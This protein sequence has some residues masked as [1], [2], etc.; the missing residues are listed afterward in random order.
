MSTL[1]VLPAAKLPSHAP[2]QR[3]LV[4]HLWG[5]EAVGIIGGE[6]KCC[7]SFLALDLAVSVASGSACLGRFPVA[8][9]ARVLLFAAEDPLHVVRERLEGITAARG[10]SLHNL[11][12]FVITATRLRLDDSGCCE[13]LGETV[14]KAAPALLVLDP[15]VRLHAVDEN[16]AGEVAPLLGFLRKLQRQHHLAVA[17]VHHARKDA[18]RSRPGQAL[19]GSSEFHAWGDSNLYLRRRDQLLRL[20]VEHRAAAAPDDLTLELATDPLALRIADAPPSEATPQHQV[21]P[22]ARIEQALLAARAPLGVR[23]LRALCHIRTDTL[24]TTLDALLAAGRVI[25]TTDGYT[26]AV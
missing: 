17:L 16:N 11:P 15:F 20:S 22:P 3:W 5:A 8:R 19:R 23:E 10:L 24:C 9:A 21:S 26:L 14:Q 4:E 2:E 18:G 6:P 7:K 25:R 13:Q 1:P 12:L